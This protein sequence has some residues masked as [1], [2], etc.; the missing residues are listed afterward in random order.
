MNGATGNGPI[1]KLAT[2]DNRGEIVNELSAAVARGQINLD[3]FEER[4]THAW[5]ARY[6]DELLQLVADITDN[7]GSLVGQGFPHARSTANDSPTHPS[8]AVARARGQITGQSDG[9]SLSLSIIGGAERSGNWVCPNTHTTIAVMGGNVVDLR[10]ARFE[11]GEIRINAFT[12]MGGIEIVVPEGVR[13]IC[14]G[15]GL[16]GGFGTSVDKKAVVQPA[17]L[18]DNA[19]VVRINGLAIMGGVSVITRPRD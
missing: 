12:V 13:V 19:P 15:V 10:E 3:E 16:M 4:S 11:S 8:Q 2:D 9:S 1:R 17:S 7:P 18:P 6:V 5:S 14:D